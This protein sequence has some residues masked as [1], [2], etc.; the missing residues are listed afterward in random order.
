MPTQTH[1]LE[2]SPT[3]LV[4]YILLVMVI[5]SLLFSSVF[6]A[7]GILIL[8][9]IGVQFTDLQRLSV[10]FH[11]LVQ[12]LFVFICAIGVYGCIA[13]R[14]KAVSLF[15]SLIIGQLL[16]SIAAGAMCL[17]FLFNATPSQPWDADRCIDTAYDEFTRQ[18]CHKTPLLKGIAVA[19]FIVMWLVEFVTIFMG[20]AHLSH[21]R[22]ELQTDIDNPKYG[23]DGNDC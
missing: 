8:Q 15:L 7:I 13:Q 22:E 20:N 5:L 9:K 16:F 14:R 11:V 2:K 12:I 1:E 23:P 3:S 19:L 6:G 18:L 21:I 10:T 17:Y 4:R